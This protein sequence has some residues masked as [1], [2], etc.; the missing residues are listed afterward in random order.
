VSA[1][2][3]TASADAVNGYLGSL[4]RSC[5]IALAARSLAT[6]ESSDI[7]SKTPSPKHSWEGFDGK[8]KAKPAYATKT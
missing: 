6:F 4:R 2:R 7:V 1:C 8:G 5:A 3:C